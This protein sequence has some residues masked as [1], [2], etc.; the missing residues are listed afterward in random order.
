MEW[1]AIFLTKSYNTIRLVPRWGLYIL[2]GVLG[3]FLMNLI[4]RGGTPAAVKA[5][6]VIPA[7][8]QSDVTGSSTAVATSATRATPTKGKGKKGKK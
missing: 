5:D 1:Q 7:N 6:P 2:T 8:T 4:H 3:S